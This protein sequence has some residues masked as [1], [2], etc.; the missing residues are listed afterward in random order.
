MLRLV[1]RWVVQHSRHR[2]AHAEA[3]WSE[4]P[5]EEERASC[6]R[7]QAGGGSASAS[8]SP[9]PPLTAPIN[10][11]K[12]VRAAPRRLVQH[13]GAWPDKSSAAPLRRHAAS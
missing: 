10:C 12:L 4:G 6:R 9:L 2:N 7:R 13:L 8:A 1:L 3:E 11:W 5:G